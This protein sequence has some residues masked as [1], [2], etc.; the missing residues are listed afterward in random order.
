MILDFRL[1]V[2]RL[3]LL[4]SFL[5]SCSFLAHVKML[6]G[7]ITFFVVVIV[8]CVLYCLLVSVVHLLVSVQHLLRLLVSLKV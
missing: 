1:F 3:F 6:L 4:F 8:Y 7:P 5:F 2:F